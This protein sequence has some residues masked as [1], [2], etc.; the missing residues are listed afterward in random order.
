MH[1][2]VLKSSY[3]FL[4]PWARGVDLEFH[5]LSTPFTDMKGTYYNELVILPYTEINDIMREP[6]SFILKS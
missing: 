4:N 2:N 6:R 3:N 5:N 1:K